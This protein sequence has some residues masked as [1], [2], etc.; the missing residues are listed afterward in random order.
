MKTAEIVLGV[1]YITTRRDT[2]I[3][4]RRCEWKTGSW[5]G[6]MAYGDIWR[7]MEGLHSSQILISEFAAELAVLRRAFPNVEIVQHRYLIGA[8]ELRVLASLYVEG[9]T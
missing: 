9:A 4:L 6:A 1:A 7:P 2:F 5:D 3:P 8:E